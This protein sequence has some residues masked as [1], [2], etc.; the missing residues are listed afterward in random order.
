ME[1]LRR[2]LAPISQPVSQTQFVIVAIFFFVFDHLVKRRN[3]KV[4]VVAQRSDA[5]VRSL[6]PA[7]VR[8]RLMADDE[9]SDLKKQVGAGKFRSRPIADLFP[10]STVMFADIAGFTAW[11][12]MREPSQVFELL[13]MLYGAFDDIAR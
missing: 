6:F 12:S 4:T 9:N 5:V 3:N 13:E 1:V 8:D 2:F 11:S 10:E 7:A